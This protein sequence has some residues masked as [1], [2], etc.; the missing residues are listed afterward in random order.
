MKQ[1]VFIKKKRNPLKFAK[2][3]ISKRRKRIYNGLSKIQKFIGKNRRKRGQSELE[4][5][6]HLP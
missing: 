2:K 1:A 4:K 6:K 5:N 3:V